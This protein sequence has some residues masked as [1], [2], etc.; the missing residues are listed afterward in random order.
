[1]CRLFLVSTSEYYD[2]GKQMDPPAKDLPLTKKIQEC[3]KSAER[4]TDTAEYIYGQSVTAYIRIA[5]N[6][7]CYAEIW[8]KYNYLS[9]VRRKQQ[10]NYGE[11]LQHYPKLLNKDLKDA[12]QT[13]SGVQIFL[14]QNS[15]G[16]IVFVYHQRFIWQQH[17]CLQNRDRTLV[18]LYLLCVKKLPVTRN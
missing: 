1:M 18:L 11:Y 15:T 3:L 9:P 7:S 14:Y 10:D 17:S 6:A 8:Q 5:K 16:N 12:D 4:P 2:F 13:K